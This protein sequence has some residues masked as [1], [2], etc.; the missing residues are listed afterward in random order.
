MKSDKYINTMKAYYERRA[1]WHD[2]YMNYTTNES[3]ESYQ[4]PIIDI[5]TQL[6]DNKDLIEIACGTGN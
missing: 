5:I 1:I 2:E 4:K 3:M 6:L